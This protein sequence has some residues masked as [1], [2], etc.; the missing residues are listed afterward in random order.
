MIEQAQDVRTTMEYSCLCGEASF[1]ELRDARSDIARGC[2][3][4]DSVSSKAV[5]L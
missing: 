2:F 3:P 1:V 4:I 5:N